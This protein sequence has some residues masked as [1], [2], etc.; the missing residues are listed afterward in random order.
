MMLKEII[1]SSQ[2]CWLCFRWFWG[3]STTSISRVI[4]CLGKSGTK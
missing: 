1:F 4:Y 2:L 3:S